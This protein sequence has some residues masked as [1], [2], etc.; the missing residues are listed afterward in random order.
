MQIPVYIKTYGCQMNER[1]SEAIKADLIDNGFTITDNEQDAEV[2]LLNTCSVRKLA[3]IKAIG[4]ANYFYRDKKKLI[5]IVGCMAQNLGYT[6]KKK[7]PWISLI[8]GPTGIHNI[9]KYI[10]QIL[11]KETDFICNTSFTGI[12]E[13][14]TSK[15][16]IHN[17]KSSMFV[18]IMQG[19]NMKCSYCIVPYTR[20][21]EQYRNM[22]SI[23]DEIKFLAD[24]GTKEVM[25][26]GQ[27]VNNY[28]LG[29][30]QYIHNKSP[31][32]QLLE[33]IQ[34]IDG[35]ERI[36][37]M[38]PHPKGFKDD[39]IS[40]YGS[41]SK[42]CLHVHLPLQSGSD[43]I[44]KAM[45]RPYTRNK[46]LEIVEKLR[47]N[48]PTISISTDIIVGFPGESDDDFQC[49]CDIF[50]AV[51]FDMAFIFKYS[52]RPGTPA[53]EM[54]MQIDDKIKEIR[55]EILLKKL[56]KYSE[57]YNKKMVGK[58]CSVLVDGPAKRGDQCLCGKISENKKVIFHGDTDNIGHFVNVQ[59]TDTLKSTLLGEMC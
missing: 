28:G 11:N 7:Y 41:L 2:V 30:Y 8:V 36:R 14:F 9:S 16:N 24:N 48:A 55:N 22:D 26:L 45:H 3:E 20:G 27:I 6:L 38:S 10:H 1:E 33:K 42:L 37:F 23:V 32:V 58:I 34:D 15:H 17:I 29:K 44:L 18:S 12:N 59:I 56:D 57:E 53:G 40:L 35:I 39:L 5:G 51:K 50:D 43:K 13:N 21:P 19:C 54:N 4:K 31:F 49:T 46:F 47:S 25:L 52:I